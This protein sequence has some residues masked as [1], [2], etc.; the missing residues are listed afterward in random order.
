[1]AVTKGTICQTM[2]NEFSTK[3]NLNFQQNGDEN[4]FF[5]NIAEGH[6]LLLSNISSALH[7]CR[8]QRQFE[9][10]LRGAHWASV[11]WIAIALLPTGREPIGSQ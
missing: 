11:P 2:K 5:K 6:R 10:K 3:K 8:Q 4:I 9:G 1:M 7:I